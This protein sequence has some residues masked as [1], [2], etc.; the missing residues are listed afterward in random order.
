MPTKITV[1]F[2]DPADPDA[3]EDGYAGHL[4]L[5]RALP[6]LQRLEAAKVWPKEDGSPT[7]AY[8][9][10]RPPLHRLRRGERGGDDARGG[11][12]VRRRAAARDG[13]VQGDLLSVEESSSPSGGRQQGTEPA[14]LLEH[15]GQ[16]GDAT[17]ILVQE[18]DDQLVHPGVR[19]PAQLVAVRRLAA[20]EASSGVLGGAVV[21]DEREVKETVGDDTVFPIEVPVELVMMIAAPAHA[22]PLVTSRL[23][24]GILRIARN[25]PAG[26]RFGG[27][28]LRR[29]PQQPA[30]RRDGRRLPA[31]PPRQRR[32]APLAR[33]P[34]LYVHAPFAAA[35]K[36][37]PVRPD[38]YAP[39]RDLEL[40]ADVDLVA[41]F[42]HERQDLAD[43]RRIR[44]QVDDLVGRPVELAAACGLGRRSREA[45]ERNLE[46]TTELAAE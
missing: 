24:E 10:R 39:L 46:Q 17:V 22:R 23:A 5:A 37:A 18:V 7:P 42:V 28:P 38:Y 36:P 20:D 25:S 33:G 19:L 9:D 31:R 3:F 13:C 4:A 16:V 26:N 35:D 32:R 27:P 40:P 43:Q 45:A 15:D 12:V 6:G 21:V 30:P 41:G 11:R 44:D 14:Q 29:R 34:L 2:D 8:R 1:L